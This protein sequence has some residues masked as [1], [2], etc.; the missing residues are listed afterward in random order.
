MS[1][2]PY[3]MMQGSNPTVGVMKALESESDVDRESAPKVSLEGE[4]WA[5]GAPVE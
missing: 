5:L 3:N 2:E 1:I 4:Q